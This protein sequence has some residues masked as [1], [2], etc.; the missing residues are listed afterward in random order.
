MRGHVGR[1][2]HHQNLGFL[3]GKH[4]GEHP[5]RGLGDGIVSLRDGGRVAS[6]VYDEL[7][8]GTCFILTG[9]LR[10]STKYDIGRVPP[11]QTGLSC[12]TSVRRL[13]KEA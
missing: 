6:G 10:G 5:V 2:N 1:R 7:G 11:T 8:L 3:C 12:S 9:L 4:L 13:E